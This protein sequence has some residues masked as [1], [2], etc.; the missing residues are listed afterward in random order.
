MTMP[1]RRGAALAI[2]LIALAFLCGG[3]GSSGDDEESDASSVRRPSFSGSV[4][5]LAEYDAET[6]WVN[7]TL[8][9]K[10]GQYL[11]SV[12]HDPASFS[13]KLVI[14]SRPAEG[15]PPPMA[16]AELARMQANWLPKYK[17]LVLKRVKLGGHST[18][19]LAYFAF[20]EDSIYYFFEECG[21]SIVFHGSTTPNAYEPFSDFYSTVV[22][23][24]KPLCDE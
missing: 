24:I 2:G 7:E 23:L 9:E 21:V 15:A 16:G 11:E 10:E 3:C 13:S 20:G 4:Y 8:D 12:W 17:E 19:R 14:D 5:H 22:S 6:T 1:G 18:I